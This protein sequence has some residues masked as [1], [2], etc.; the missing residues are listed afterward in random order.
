[1]SPIEDVVVVVVVVV[2]IVVILAVLIVII[3][4]VVIAV[5]VVIVVV[6]LVALG[7]RLRGKPA[8]NFI[9]K[10]LV[11]KFPYLVMFEKATRLHPGDLFL[12]H[13]PTPV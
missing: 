10:D 7:D 11:V 9:T 5:V 13:S 6:A 3:F 12:V 8:F 1:M 2:V 4:V